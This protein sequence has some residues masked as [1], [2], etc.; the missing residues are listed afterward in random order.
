MKSMVS[1]TLQRNLVLWPFMEDARAFVKDE[2]RNP[3]IS[4]PASVRVGSSLGFQERYFREARQKATAAAF[5]RFLGLSTGS[6][7]PR[8]VPTIGFGG[9]G[10]GHRAMLGSLGALMA[11]ED[12]GL[13]DATMYLAGVVRLRNEY[14]WPLF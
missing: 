3:E 1:S 10:G 11:M 2:K 12:E 14:N 5:E 4:Q 7:N 8:D 13:L 6:V 9:S